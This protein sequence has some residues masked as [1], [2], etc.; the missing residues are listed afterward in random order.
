VVIAFVDGG[1]GDTSNVLRGSAPA[2][3]GFDHS[4]TRSN[5]SIN[6]AFVGGIP[7]VWLTMSQDFAFV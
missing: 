3:V 5:D 6:D 7:D 1:V 2:Q 4:G